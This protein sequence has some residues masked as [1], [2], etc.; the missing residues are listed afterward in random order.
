MVAAWLEIW[1]FWLG[2][3]VWKLE[4]TRIPTAWGFR[5]VSSEARVGEHSGV[6]WKF[7]YRRPAP[8]KASICGVAMSDP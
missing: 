4:T 8:A 1:A 2:K 3:P 7:V 6:T 5:P